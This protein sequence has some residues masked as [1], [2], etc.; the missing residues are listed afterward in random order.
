M[1]FFEHA[2]VKLSSNIVPGMPSL[3]I[4][5]ALIIFTLLPLSSNQQPGLGEKAF[6]LAIIFSASSFQLILV[7][8]FTIFLA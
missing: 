7:S 4:F 8:D 5:L 2:I 6:I 3:I 1:A